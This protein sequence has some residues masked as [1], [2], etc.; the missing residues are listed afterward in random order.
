MSRTVVIALDGSDLSM[1]ALPFAQ[2]IAFQWPARLVLVH[3]ADAHGG[4][5]EA[6]LENEL[7]ELVRRLLEQGIDASAEVRAASAALLITDVARERTADL[8]VM[9]SHQR[10]GPNRWLNGSIAE[11]VLARSPIPLLVVPAHSEPSKT[12]AMRV[13]VPFDGSVAGEA[14]LEFLRGWSTVRPLELVLVRVVSNR[15]VLEGMDPGVVV[16]PLSDEDIQAEVNDASE[17]LARLV[18]TLHDGQ[19]VARHSVIESAD[20]VANVIVE[21]ARSEGVD[22]IALG[23]HARAGISRLVLGS[24]SEEVLE[25]SPLPV[26]LVRRQS[27]RSNASIALNKVDARP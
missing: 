1:Q 4:Q 6:L 20:R 21:T 12:G 24:Q 26:L 16:Q 3:A 7:R 22:I 27:A 8:I 23:T 13:L 2:T 15:P 5:A 10:H 14:A 17:Y 25:H 19:M 11:E 18:A 9:A